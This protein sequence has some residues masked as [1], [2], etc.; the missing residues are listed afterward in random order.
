MAASTVGCHARRRL[1]TDTHT[2][3][4]HLA[5][6]HAGV[7]GDEDIEFAVTFDHIGTLCHADIA[8]TGQGTSDHGNDG[9]CGGDGGCSAFP[10]VQLQFNIMPEAADQLDEV[11]QY[12]RQRT[13]V[14]VHDIRLCLLPLSCFA[15]WLMR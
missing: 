14:C 15:S 13:G 3:R 11:L 1:F 12:V 6:L 9:S 5:D 8:D 2:I 7:T 4:P 10:D